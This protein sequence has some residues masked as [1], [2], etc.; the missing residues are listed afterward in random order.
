MKE[1]R[2]SQGRRENVRQHGRKVLVTISVC[3]DGEMAID[4]HV[5]AGSFYM[6]KL[7]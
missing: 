5:L 3:K 2:V 7:Y 1:W 6:H 4:R